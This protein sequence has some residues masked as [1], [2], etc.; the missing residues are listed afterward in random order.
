MIAFAKGVERTDP[1]G[2]RRTH[3]LKGL[4]TIAPG[5]TSG[6]CCG[7]GR[8]CRFTTSLTLMKSWRSA[9]PSR[10]SGVE[11]RRRALRERALGAAVMTRPR[12]GRLFAAERR[13]WSRSDA[14]TLSGA[15]SCGW[16][17]SAHS[18]HRL[19]DDNLQTPGWLHASETLSSS[20]RC[21][22]GSASFQGERRRRPRKGGRCVERE[23][24]TCRCFSSPRLV[25]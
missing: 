25:V 6:S 1:L 20:H 15:V 9:V 2:G 24:R 18:F 8:A 3:G 16:Q 5:T 7:L 22:I 11:P 10:P 17:S 12:A 13:S 19:R 21:P 14:R 23:K 4:K